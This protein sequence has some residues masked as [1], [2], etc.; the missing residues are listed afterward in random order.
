MI[1]VT[2]GGRAQCDTALVAKHLGHLRPIEIVFCGCAPGYD[3][4]VREWCER[5]E[6]SN[7]VARAR[8][9]QYGGHAGP[10][11]NRA[12]LVRAKQLAERENWERCILLAFPGWEGTRSCVQMGHELGFEIHDATLEP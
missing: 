9:R 6:V 4:A 10:M 12:M 3:K 2:T 1:V 11:R 8:W 7:F 5:N